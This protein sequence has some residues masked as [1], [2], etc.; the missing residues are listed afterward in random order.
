[1][2]CGQTGFDRSELWEF[3]PTSV[4]FLPD[5]SHTRGSSARPVQ[6]A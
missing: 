4:L 6:L 2:L 3:F 5:L 1:M